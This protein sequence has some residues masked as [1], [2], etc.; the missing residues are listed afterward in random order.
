LINEAG[1]TDYPLV[2]FS[3]LM[4]Y[5]SLDGIYGAAYNLQKAENLVDWLNWTVTVGQTYSAELY[6]VPLPA[7]VTLADQAS[8]KA[9]TYQ[10]ATI[11]VCTVT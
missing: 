9:I 3:Y 2:T 5:E 7:S 4:V 8:I 6:Y 11:P 10:G 1:A